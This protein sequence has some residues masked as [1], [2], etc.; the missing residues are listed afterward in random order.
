MPMRLLV[1]GGTVFLGRWVVVEAL[2]REH[3]VTVFHRGVHNHGL[4][5]EVE[6][7]LGD[8]TEDLSALEGR[9]WDAVIDTCGHARGAVAATART[10]ADSVEHYGF[11]SSVA[12]YRDWPR[13]SVADEDAP[14]HV[15]DAEE[16]GPLKAACERA[17]EQ[18]M[19]GRAA[20]VR[21]GAIVGPHEYVGRLPWWLLRMERGGPVLAPGPPEATIQLIDARDLAAFML[22][23]AERRQAGAYNAVSPPGAFAWGR[24]L[25]AC[26]D[27]V[28]GDAELVWVDGERVASALDE[29]W[30]RLPL[31]P[32]AGPAT[33]G[34]YAVGVDRALDAGLT[35]RP[36]EET[37]EDTWA[38]MPLDEGSPAYLPELRVTGLDPRRETVLLAALS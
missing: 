33:A 25:E 13:G 28:G 32:I 27:V 10:L 15:S 21:A 12:A 29:P 5:P 2:T 31:W 7:L 17:L 16:H 9:G 22:E 4:F 34:L 6:T 35:G 1:I 23:L 18:A 37:I 36:L 19:P 8:R 20:H 3:E 38:L 14:L 30:S 24:L 26:R 11:V